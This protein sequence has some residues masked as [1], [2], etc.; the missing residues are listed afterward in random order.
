MPETS[1]L[2]ALASRNGLSFSAFDDTLDFPKTYG[3]V[4]YAAVGRRTESLD[5]DNPTGIAH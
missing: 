5:D 4:G 1:L 3:N 2:T